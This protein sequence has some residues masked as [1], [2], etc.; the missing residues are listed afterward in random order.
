MAHSNYE[1]MRNQMRGEFIKYDQHTM[2][3]KFS[4]KC[5]E[6]YIYIEFVKRNY[7]IHR[8]NGI[9]EWSDDNFQTNIEADYNESMTI[10]DVL[11]CSK[12]NPVLAGRYSPINELKGTIKSSAAGTNFYQKA[13]DS[14]NE[15][16][17]ALE[18]ACSILGKNTKMSGDVAAILYPFSFLPVTLQYWEGDDEFPANLKFMFDENIFDFMHF[19]TTFFMM[20]HVTKRL[21]EIVNSYVMT[22]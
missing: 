5:D 2:I 7:R 9:V 15:K 22:H 8:H 20:N 18:Y 6:E 14:F 17:T 12:E 16:T 10:Y 1:I 19:E 11:C 4:L 21:T 3:H 13:A